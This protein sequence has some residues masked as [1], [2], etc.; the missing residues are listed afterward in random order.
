MLVGPGLFHTSTK[1]L[2]AGGLGIVH[3]RRSACAMRTRGSGGQ[4]RMAKRFGLVCAAGLALAAACSDTP[5]SAP[6]A[7]SSSA[8]TTVT[9]P[10]INNFVVYAAN[11]VTLGASNHSVGGNIGVATSN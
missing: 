1:L 6:I 4:M 9:T 8:V 10:T 7:K 5:P 11:N 2:L 3:R